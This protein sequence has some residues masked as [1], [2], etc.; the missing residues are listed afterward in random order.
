MAIDSLGRYQ[1]VDMRDRVRRLLDSLNIVVSTTDGS[2]TSS[3][4]QDQSYSNT[5]INN[6][7]NESLTSLYCEMIIGKDTL[8]ASTIYI[9]TTANNPGP[10]AFPANM[11]Q[12]RWMKWKDPTTPFTP[13][14]GSPSFSPLP[15]EW[16]PMALVD[17]PS[18]W[19]DQEAYNVP[20]WRW[21]SGQFFLNE[22]VT[23]ANNNGIMANIVTLPTELTKD[24]DVIQVPQFVRVLQQTV[25]YDAAFTLGFSK[26]EWVAPELA[27]KRDAWHQRLM[28]MVENAYKTMSVQMV[29]PKRMV[30][31]TYTGRFRNAAGTAKGF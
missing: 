21:E 14:L 7:I 30:R 28:T 10:Y 3:V 2:E 29:A 12:L 9:S 26:K 25:I 27:Q 24:T 22:I 18:D 1:L 8:F 16:Y 31:N 19:A 17:D 4:V 6:Q 13:T 15:I 5:D 11:L 20:T 23:I